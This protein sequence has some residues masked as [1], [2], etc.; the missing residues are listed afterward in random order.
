MLFT[1]SLLYTGKNKSHLSIC[2]LLSGS[3]TWIRGWWICIV[4]EARHE[5]L[6]YLK[7]ILISVSTKLRLY[8]IDGHVYDHVRS[9][10]QLSKS[11]TNI[12]CFSTYLAT[13]LLAISPLTNKLQV[14]FKTRTFDSKITINLEWPEYQFLPKWR[15]TLT[16]YLPRALVVTIPDCFQNQYSCSEADK[17]G[18]PA[19]VRVSCVSFVRNVRQLS[20]PKLSIFECGADQRFDLHNN[21]WLDSLT[22]R[23]YAAKTR[24][25]YHIHL[26]WG[27]LGLVRLINIFKKLNK[28]LRLV[29]ICKAKNQ[30]LHLVNW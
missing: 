15:I 23:V 28:G 7:R 30:L 1:I 14:Y 25:V 10:A 20:Q 6:G 18:K 21:F 17:D 12:F 22:A 24:V 3:P 27:H 13:F 8:F 19:Y 16:S 29:D 2:E 5:L 9:Y 4:R 26:N 11:C